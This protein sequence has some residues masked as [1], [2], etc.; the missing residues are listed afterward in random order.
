MRI[1]YTPEQKA[2][3]IEVYNETRSYAKTLRILG[4]PSRHVLLDWVKNPGPKP[5]PK[6]TGRPAK[7]YGWELKSLAVSKVL[8]GA[9]IKRVAEELGVTNYATIYEWIRKWRTGGDV[10]LMSKKEQL[11]AGAYKTRAQLEAALPELV[12]WTDAAREAD[13]RDADAPVLTHRDLDPKNVLWRGLSPFLIDW[14]AA[15]YAR[16]R[17]ELLEVA[18]YWA[19]DGEGGLDGALCEALLRAYGRHMPLRG[20]WTPVFAAGRANLLAWLAYSVRRASGQ[21]S[22]DAEEVRLGAAEVG[23]TLGALQGYEAKAKV[24]EG[25]L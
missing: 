17:R 21:T 18:L 24:I 15:G 23:K 20:D 16:P 3:A 11:E 14:E 22:P 4:Y 6:Q 2:K 13:A 19:D 25:F 5:K 7:R 1:S 9:D 8:G 12:A 10:G